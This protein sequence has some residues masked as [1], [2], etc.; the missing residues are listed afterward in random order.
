[1]HCKIRKLKL[2][3]KQ[4]ELDMSPILLVFS[5]ITLAKSLT[6]SLTVLETLSDDI[7]IISISMQMISKV[8]LN[9]QL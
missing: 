3:G 2:Q 5:Q 6:L 9:M 1:M 7:L 4:T 8:E